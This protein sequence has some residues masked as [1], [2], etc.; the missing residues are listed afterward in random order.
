MWCRY[1]RILPFAVKAKGKSEDTRRHVACAI[2]GFGETF[3]CLSPFARRQLLKNMPTVAEFR[4]SLKNEQL[5]DVA[6]KFIFSG[7]SYVFEG[8]SEQESALWD[9]LACGL[10]VAASDLCIVGSAKTGFSLSPDNFPRQFSDS[11][12]ID[13]IVV[14]P[15]IFDDLWLSLLKWHYSFGGPNASALNHRWAKERIK[16]VYWG[17]FSPASLKNSTLDASP[18]RIS[19]VRDLAVRWFDTLKST[20][21][22]PSLAARDVNARLYRTWDHAQRYHVHGLSLLKQQLKP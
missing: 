20:S 12:D 17:Y 21:L 18:P 19:A 6:N 22:I 15:A 10:G 1:R 9:H 16:D 14:S 3:S 11:S 13:V 5:L 8:N 2:I 4:E 7:S